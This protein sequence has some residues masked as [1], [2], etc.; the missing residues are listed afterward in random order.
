MGSP[1]NKIGFDHYKHYYERVTSPQMLKKYP[2]GSFTNRAF[3]D[4]DSRG[5]LIAPSKHQIDEQ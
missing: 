3:V 2:T 5:F 4:L 1:S